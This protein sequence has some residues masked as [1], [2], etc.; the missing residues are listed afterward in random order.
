MKLLHP[1]VFIP[2]PVIAARPC[3]ETA[4]AGCPHRPGCCAFCAVSG[5]VPLPPWVSVV[6]LSPFYKSETTALMRWSDL[7][8][9][10]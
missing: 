2:R 5:S 4:V 7:S 10:T 6:S 1:S 8:K 3:V 9:V